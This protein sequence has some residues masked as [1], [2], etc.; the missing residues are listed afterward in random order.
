MDTPRETIEIGK[1]L[2]EFCKQNENLKAVNELYADEIV[3]L[4]SMSS[5]QGTDQAQGIEAIR[6]KNKQ[7][8]DEMEVHEM[9]VQGPFPLGDR[10]AVHFKFDAFFVALDTF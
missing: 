5:P 2:V 9:D 6:R 8:E 7:W 1:K 10:F 4:E 3:S